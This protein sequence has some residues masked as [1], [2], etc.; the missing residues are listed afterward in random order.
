MSSRSNRTKDCW[1]CG[2]N[3]AAAA[4][5]DL[6]PKCRKA[7]LKMSIKAEGK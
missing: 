2:R 6:C 3:F 4:K 7:Y 5:R 1:F